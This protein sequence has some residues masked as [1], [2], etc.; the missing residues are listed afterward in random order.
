MATSLSSIPQAVVRTTADHTISTFFDVLYAGG[1]AALIKGGV[2][3]EPGG[4]AFLGAITLINV[5]ISYFDY[6]DS[7]KDSNF[8]SYR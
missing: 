5:A 6:T 8:G 3:K 7:Y 2:L 1:A 4:A